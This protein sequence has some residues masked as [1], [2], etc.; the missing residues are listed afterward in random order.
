MLQK[1]SPRI[2]RT[3]LSEIMPDS[4]EEISAEVVD[5]VDGLETVILYIDTSKGVRTFEVPET[6]PFDET[7]HQKGDY[8]ATE[9]D[10][11]LNVKCNHGNYQESKQEL[12]LD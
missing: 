5:V 1:I 2:Y 3:A 6:S 9:R 7:H 8:R 11:L 4:P 10:G 12:F